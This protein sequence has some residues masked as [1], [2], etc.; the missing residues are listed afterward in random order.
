M[1]VHELGH[2]LGLWHEHCRPDRDAHVNV[3]W[4]NIKDASKHNFDKQVDARLLTPYDMFSI[5][6]YEPRV[7]ILSCAKIVI[8][9]SKNVVA[10]KYHDLGKN[11]VGRSGYIYI[12]NFFTNCNIHNFSS[13]FYSN[14]IIA[15]RSC[16]S[17]KL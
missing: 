3:L 17:F 11:R 4:K 13:E 10:S 7:S 8:G 9:Q 1:I 16:F 14:T 6:H 15:F 5:M 2:A 12:L